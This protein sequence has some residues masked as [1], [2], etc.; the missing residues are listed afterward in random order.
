[1]TRT[2]RVRCVNAAKRAQAGASGLAR[3]LALLLT[4]WRSCLRAA[5]RQGRACCASRLSGESMRPSARRSRKRMTRRSA[6]LAPKASSIAAPAFTAAAA[7]AGCD[8]RERR[9]KRCQGCK[10]KRA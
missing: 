3:H 7:R 1:M 6:Q 10:C 9:E 8:G 2:Q 4:K 5:L